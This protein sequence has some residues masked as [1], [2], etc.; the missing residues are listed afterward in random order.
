VRLQPDPRAREA[1]RPWRV[2]VLDTDR[3]SRTRLAS[4]AAEAGV[5]VGLAGAPRADVEPLLQHTRCDAI[6]LGLDLLGESAPPLGSGP[7]Y[8]VVVCSGDTS[9]DMVSIAQRIGAMAFLVR[10][11]R[12]EQIVPTLALAVSRFEERRRLGQAL[13]ERKLIERAKGRLMAVRG[14]TE[15]AAFRVLRRRAMDSRSRIADVARQ[16]LDPP[17]PNPSRGTL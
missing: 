13:A 8:P 16:V 14:L 9:L 3:A 15:D 17:P 6:L 4:L 1:A 2:A 5:E 7:G 11:I 12:R 10:P